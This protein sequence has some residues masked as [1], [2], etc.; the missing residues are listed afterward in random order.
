MPFAE[1][2]T[3]AEQQTI[4]RR[5]AKVQALIEVDVLNADDPCPICI[6]ISADGP[7]SIDEA[8]GLIP[9]HPNCLLPRQSIHGEVVAGS[10]AFYAGPAI[11]IITARG[12][13]LRLTVNHP[14]LTSLGLV[15]AQDLRQGMN[16]LSYFK[17]SRSSSASNIGDDQNMINIW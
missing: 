5:E 3:A 2:L 13:R 9:A 8:E 4:E 10:K 6:E 1:P 15:S 11:E 17:D 14:I 12:N 7:Y 16:L